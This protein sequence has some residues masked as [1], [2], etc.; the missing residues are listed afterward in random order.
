M[1][2]HC[3]VWKLIT[4]KNGSVVSYSSLSHTQRFVS[5][6]KTG[7]QETAGPRTRLIV[8][9]SDQLWEGAEDV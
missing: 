1:P 3:Y 6:I 4:V 8:L 5:H 9:E 2:L 7:H